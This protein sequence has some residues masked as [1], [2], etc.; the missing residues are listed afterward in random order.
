MIG[1]NLARL[2]AQ[3]GHHVLLSFAR[4]TDKLDAL[5][6]EIGPNARVGTPAEAVQ[7]GDVVV[8][9]V[10]FSAMDTAIAQLGD[11]T[12]KILVDTNN[13]FEIKL[14][15]GMTAA[16]EVLRRIPGVRLVKA[17]NTLV[18]SDLLSKSHHQ[19]PY[20]LPY[21]GNDD[22]ANEQVATLILQI[23][24]APVL[25]GTLAEVAWQEAGGPLYGQALTPER[26]HSI[27]AEAQG[28]RIAA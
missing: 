21:A 26:A 12:G 16:G 6:A 14:S 8:L 17:F 28:K 15:S 20:A 5:A 27:V 19:P 18:Y 10:H 22:G 3:A 7:F 13:A 4:S 1:G 2:F 24:F 23:G 25:T 11:A 9:S